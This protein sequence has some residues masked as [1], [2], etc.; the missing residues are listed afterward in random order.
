MNNRF[1]KTAL[2]FA[3]TLGTLAAA[4]VG[5]AFAADATP[6]A[7][8]AVPTTASPYDGADQYLSARGVPQA[9]YIVSNY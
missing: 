1:S 9:G 6:A 5:A 2:A 8:S 3:L 7:K 4:P